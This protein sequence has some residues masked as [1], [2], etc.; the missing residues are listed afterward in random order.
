MSYIPRVVIDCIL[1][2]GLNLQP[3]F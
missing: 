1:R 2:G 3:S